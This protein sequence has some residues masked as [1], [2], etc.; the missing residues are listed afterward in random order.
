MQQFAN[1]KPCKI[2]CS[3]CVSSVA[4]S[5]SFEIEGT[6]S[7]DFLHQV[8]HQTTSFG[9]FRGTLRSSDQFKKYLNSKLTPSGQ[10]RI[11]H[12]VNCLYNEKRPKKHPNDAYNSGELPGVAYTNTVFREIFSSW[13]RLDH[14]K[15][16]IKELHNP[17]EKN[18]N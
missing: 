17:V 6:V 15:M 1:L 2:L 12:G 9:P 10:W 16:S 14:P 13:D 7:Q 3:I 8:S 11:R 5:I 4:R 18:H